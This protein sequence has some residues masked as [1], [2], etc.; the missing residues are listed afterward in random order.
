ML[1]FQMPVNLTRRRG[2][3]R[4]KYEVNSDIEILDEDTRNALSTLESNDGFS[5]QFRHSPTQF[6]L[7]RYLID[8]WVLSLSGS[9]SMT[10]G[11]LDRSQSKSLQ[12][13]VAYD[14]RIPG[15]HD[16]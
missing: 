16:F 13:S 3:Q 11:P 1:G 6:F 14:L 10:R 2:V 15:R 7:T 5:A 4:P 8:P 12:G 9:R